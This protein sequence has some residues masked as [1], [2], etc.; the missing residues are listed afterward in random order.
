MGFLEQLEKA[1]REELNA[2][3]QY[4][5]TAFRSFRTCKQCGK[6]FLARYRVLCGGCIRMIFR[7]TGTVN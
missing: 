4:L 3:G 1:I 7:E 2:R 5:G 6:R